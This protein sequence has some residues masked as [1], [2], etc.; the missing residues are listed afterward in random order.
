MIDLKAFRDNPTAFRDAAKAKNVEIDIERI[1]ELDKRVRFLKTELEN[2]SAQKNEAS[3]QIAKADPDTRKTLIEE[4]RVVDRKAET[5]DTE[6]K[7]LASELEDALYRIPNPSTPDVKIGA[8]DAENEV[9]REVGDRTAFSFKPKDHIELG[10]ALGIIDVEAGAKASGARFAYFKG[11]AVMLELALVQY[12]FAVMARHGFIPAT[13]PHLVS[14][15]VMR[16]MGYLEHGG[17]DEIYFLAKDNLYLIGTAE[18]A[19]GAVHMDEILSHT[20]LPRRYVGYSPC[21]RREAG[22]YGKD[23]RGIL[24][25]HQFDKIEMFSF[26]TPEASDTEHELLLSVE[27]ELMQGL[28]LP[29]RVIKQCTGDLGLPAAR[30]YDIEA[31]MPSQDT[32]RETH[33]T[34]TCTDYQARRLNTRYRDEEGNVKLVHTLNGTGFAVGRTMIAIMEN[35]QQEDGSIVIP[36]ALRPFMG[37]KEKMTKV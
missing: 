4:M 32:Y 18:Q 31:W 24:R 9:V 29:Y 35:N 13:V 34:S 2:T 10:E 15:R 8:S 23:T 37:G 28:G 30:K 11:D 25:M 6:L 26:T 21:Y 22:S 20:T 17:H 16:A 19:L 5:L 33:S 27:E 12:A 14:A 3:K 7:P 1:M 36:E